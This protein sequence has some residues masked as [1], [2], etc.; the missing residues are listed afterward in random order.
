MAIVGSKGEGGIGVDS[1]EEKLGEE[2]IERSRSGG[3]DGLEDRI[4]LEDCG[5]VV[6]T[7][8]CRAVVGEDCR[9]GGELKSCS[10]AGESHMQL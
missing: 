5:G 3:I 2:D 1:S 7:E 10:I 9:S 6:G 4:L 8:D